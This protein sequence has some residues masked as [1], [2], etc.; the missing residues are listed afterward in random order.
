M[1][2][3]QVDVRGG[4]VGRT[5]EL[6]AIERALRSARRGASWLVVAGEAGIGKSRLLAAAA[7]LADGAGWRVLPGRATELEREQPFGVVVDALDDFVG[8]LSSARLRGFS[9]EQRANLT[10]VFPSLEG[11]GGGGGGFA[12]LRSERY[13][14]HRAV[15]ALLELLASDRP[16]PLALDDLHWADEA[17]VEL[18]D[19]LLRHPPRGRVLLAL[20]LTWIVGPVIRLSLSG[21]GRYS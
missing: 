10:A 4:V 3:Q 21:R 15:R 18:I 1:R 11:E 2:T 16:L 13:R 7:D 8:S 14:A 6:P 9:N 19:H 12:A 17:S 5:G 20:T